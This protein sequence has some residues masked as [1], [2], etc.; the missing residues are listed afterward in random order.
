[1]QTM[2]ITPDL[3]TRE[4]VMAAAGRVQFAVRDLATDQVRYVKIEAKVKK[5][6]GQGYERGTRPLDEATH[7]FISEKGYGTPRIGTYY[8][9]KKGY[10]AGRFFPANDADPAFIQAMQVV[11]NH[12]NGVPTPDG[13][14]VTAESRCGLCGHKL[15]DPE[16]VTRGIGPECAQKPTGMKILHS[17]KFG[18]QPLPLDEEQP[19]RDDAV[20]EIERQLRQAEADLAAAEQAVRDADRHRLDL[21]EALAEAKEFAQS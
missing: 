15:E 12:V 7:V 21:I 10:D 1:M 5:D 19:E 18:Q 11:I 17:S 9:P 3:Q 4:S 6:G 2:T 8:P 20:A 16:S 14:Q 13:L